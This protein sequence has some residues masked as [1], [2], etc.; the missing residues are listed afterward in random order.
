MTLSLVVTPADYANLGAAGIAETPAEKA[1]GA[2]LDADRPT[3]GVRPSASQ[4]AIYDPLYSLSAAQIPA[5]LN[6]MSPTIHADAL[7]AARQSWY[8]G[9]G[10]IGDQLTDRRGMPGSGAVAAGLQGVTSW[11]DVVG[12]VTDIGPSGARYH[13]S[14]GDVVVGVDKALGDRGLIGFAV[15]GGNVQTG[16]AAGGANGDL[17]QAAIYGSASRGSAFVQ[18][19]ADYLHIDQDVTRVLGFAGASLKGHDTL[20]GGGGQVGAGLDLAVMTWLVEPSVGLSAV[21][22]TST[23]AHEGAGAA[24]AESVSGQ[25]INSLQSNVEVHVARM[26]NL[27]PQTPLEVHALIGWDHELDDTSA[28]ARA[29]LAGLGG[30]TFTTA[31]APVGRD[32]IKLGAGFEAQLTTKIIVYGTYSAALASQRSAQD[33]SIGARLRW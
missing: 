12:Q 28:L 22:L 3:A 20:Q 26:V 6:E 15:G 21:G 33:L 7:M 11:G 31:S 5:A 25:N 1:V 13:S 2:M 32:A 24:L 30:G 14:V 4:A 8:A 23:A 27:T 17:I 16:A 29:S 18:W 10:A 9:A 19:Q